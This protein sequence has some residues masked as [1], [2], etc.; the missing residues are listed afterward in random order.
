MVLLF[1][2]LA[3][4]SVILPGSCYNRLKSNL[5][6]QYPCVFFFAIEFNRSLSS[7]KNYFSLSLCQVVC[8]CLFILTGK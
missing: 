8:V 2:I 3:I 1:L 4:L 7:F 5:L 6:S